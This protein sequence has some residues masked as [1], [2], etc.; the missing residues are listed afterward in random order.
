MRLHVP[1]S[2]SWELGNQ[3]RDVVIHV[4]EVVQNTS[5]LLEVFH[6]S[7]CLST[8]ASGSAAIRVAMLMTGGREGLRPAH[9]VDLVNGSGDVG[10]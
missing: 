6:E 1:S 8:S 5:V 2:T 10:G 7:V 9:V 4:D 3:G